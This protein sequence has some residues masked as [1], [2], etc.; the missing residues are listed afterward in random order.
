[1][2]CGVFFLFVGF[3]WMLVC[4]GWFMLALVALN[5]WL[6]VAGGCGGGFG[7]GGMCPS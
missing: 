3:G 6:D 5:V 7:C 4:S 1:M 2:A